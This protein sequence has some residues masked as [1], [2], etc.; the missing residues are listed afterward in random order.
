MGW[1]MLKRNKLCLLLAGFIVFCL[2]GQAQAFDLEEKVVKTK[3]EN[4][5]TVLMVTREFSPTVSLYIRF[6]VGAVDEIK[7][8]SGA[9]HF[10]E[11][12]M[13]KGTSSIGTKDY[14]AEK[15][16]L[17]QIES[18]GQALDNEKMRQTKADPELIEKLAARLKQLQDEHRQY[19]IPNEI[20]RLY[21]QN[22]GQ[23]MNA[24]TGQD[25]TTYHISLPA[26]KIELWARI[27]SDR[28]VNP[29]F[30]EFYSERDVILEE[31]RQ[32]V[33]TRPEGKLYESFM[34][35]AYRV[36]PYGWPILGWPEDLT[37]MSQTAIRQIHRKYL[38]PEN[39][40]IAVVGHIHPPTILK[41]ID[42][43]FG[44]IPKGSSAPAVI[45]PEPPQTHER[46]IEVL[47]DA[48]P[49]MMIGYHKPNAPAFEDDVFD[50]LET[51]LSRGRTSRL[52]ARL[53]MELQIAQSIS[54]HNGLPA[55]RYPNLFAIIAH[56]RH[57]HTNVDIEAVL[58]EEIDKIK[59]HP[60]P[61]EELAKA[62]KQMKMDY[63]KS[64]DSNSQ[65]ASILSYYELLLGDYRYFS[66]YIA[67]IDRVTATDLMAAARKYLTK[68]NRTVAYLTAKKDETMEADRHEK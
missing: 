14:R 67:R 15:K 55:S 44:R 45:P 27:E 48:N 25:V 57:P 36:H 21:T 17:G 63:L 32:R 7:G 22:G 51:I 60:V 4:G 61:D 12:M 5:L 19:Y 2:A 38:A 37:A 41:L 18:I 28:L 24:S 29:V 34:S 56:P 23:D 46:R 6:R 9:A 35:T 31:R 64:L 42:R 13:F 54:V 8:Q 68:E 65:L 49:M 47:F 40:V 30:R 11:H 3:L 39:I 10:L 16:L 50:V 62:K 58:L 20:D 66:D 1:I 26:N 52:Y 43:Y 33:E 59:S 53:V